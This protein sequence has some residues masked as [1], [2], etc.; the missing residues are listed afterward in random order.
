MVP[1]L[2]SGIQKELEAG[3][4]TMATLVVQVE[5]ESP[6]EAFVKLHGKLVPLFTWRRQGERRALSRCISPSI[7]FI[8]LIIFLKFSINING[9][10]LHSKFKKL[11]FWSVELKC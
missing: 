7:A 1:F 11:K 5:G 9:F 3:P 6:W 8:V 4:T 2:E 10:N